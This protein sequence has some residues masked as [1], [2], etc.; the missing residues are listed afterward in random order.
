VTKKRRIMKEFRVDEISA[1]DFPAQV[2]ARAVIMKR[3]PTDAEKEK[4]ME[5]G[6]VGEDPP[7]KNKKKQVKDGLPEPAKTSKN[8]SGDLNAN[9]AEM[10]KTDEKTAENEAVTKLAEMTKRAERAEK[11]A[12]LSDAQRGIFKSLEGDAP[13]EFLALTSDQREVEVAKASDANAVVYTDA[14]GMENR[15]SDDSRLVAMAKRADEERALRVATEEKAVL[16]DLAKRAETLKHIPGD[17]E[18]R[19]DLLKGVD[20]LPEDKREAAMAALVAHDAGLAK[21][22]ES[23]GASNSGLGGDVLENVAE[24]IRTADSSLTAEQA[25]VKALDTPEGQA[26]YAKSVGY[27]L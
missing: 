9:E 12:E 27:K 16:N 1:V 4:A 25:M 3:E 18:A 7:S 21:S 17:L 11:I 2:T 22:F 8:T 24:Q 23:N 5:A 6:N 13:D 20:S 19:M 10:A 15:K 14:T 26:A